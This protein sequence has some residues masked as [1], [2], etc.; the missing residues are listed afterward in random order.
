MR[1]QVLPW[2]WRWRKGTKH[3]R[4]TDL[5]E[6]STAQLW[7]DGVQWLLGRKTAS[8]GGRVGVCG[9]GRMSRSIHV[10]WSGVESFKEVGMPAAERSSEGEAEF[11]SEPNTAHNI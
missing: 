8:A 3:A 5:I 7:L 10:Y 6:S 9:H 4:E 11:L 1:A 2:G